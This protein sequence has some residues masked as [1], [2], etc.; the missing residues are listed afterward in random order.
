M[1]AIRN[2]GC[3]LAHFKGKK[4]RQKDARGRCR[5]EAFPRRKR[6]WPGALRAAAI[7]RIP[8]SA[9]V[10]CRRTNPLRATTGARQMRLDRVRRIC[11]Q[12]IAGRC[13]NRA[14]SYR[15]RLFRNVLLCPAA[16]RQS[17]STTTEADDRHWS[18]PVRRRAPPRLFRDAGRATRTPG[19][20]IIERAHRL[21]RTRRIER[22]ASTMA[23][24]V[25]MLGASINS[26][27]DGARLWNRPYTLWR[28]DR[29]AICG[30]NAALH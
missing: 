16:S 17:A 1:R 26:R 20:A 22:L 30:R 13:I 9:A 10:L 23:R 5:V 2:A 7:R 8:G 3:I 11:T 15:A 27:F 24:R 25:R 29:P 28:A 21:H 14:C 4:K 12:Q 6:P 19:P 18:A